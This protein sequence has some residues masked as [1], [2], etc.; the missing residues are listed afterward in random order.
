MDLSIFRKLILSF[1]PIFVAIGPLGNIPVF[2]SLTHQLQRKEKF[3]VVRD[4]VITASL[5]VIIFIYIGK[6]IFNLLG[7]TVADF[8]IAGGILLLL[9]AIKILLGNATIKPELQKIGV[10]PL[11]TPMVAGPAVFT[12]VL[13]L[14]DIYGVTITVISLILNVILTGMIFIHAE[15][16]AKKLGAGGTLAMSKIMGILLASIAVMMVRKGIFEVIS[17]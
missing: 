3:K 9:I 12:T 2:I 14:V 1:I 6:T 15:Y 17:T 5:A 4:I 10:V 11:G 13:I 16:L 7:I 8:K